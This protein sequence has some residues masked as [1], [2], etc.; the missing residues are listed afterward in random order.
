MGP[1]SGR[2]QGLWLWSLCFLPVSWALTIL[3]EVHVDG[4]LGGSIIIKCPIPKM[5]VRMYLCR[6]TSRP[7]ICATVV[8]SNNFIKKEYMGR[9]TLLQ[10]P[11]KNLFLVKMT[12]LT[13]NDSGD[14]A[15][16]VGTHTDRGK[17]QKVTLNIHSEYEPLWEEDPMPEPPKWFH[18]FLHQQ[19]PY[20]FQMPT[21]ASSSKFT[22]KVIT[23]AQRTE[24]PPVYQPSTTTLTIHHPRVSRASSVAAA[25]SPTLLPSTTV[26]KTSAQEGLL[27]P[28]TASYN[29]HS[30]LHRQRAFNHG[31]HS[32]REG[33]GFHILIPTILGL[34]LI[35]L[36][37]LL[38]K[39]AI[40][41]RKALSRRVRRLAV[42]MRALEAS[43]RP[44]ASRRLRSQNNVYSA[45]PRRARP[46]DAAGEGEAPVPG[47][48]MS[49]PPAPPQE[50]EAPWL[51][52]S[53]LKT[54]S[55]YIP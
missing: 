33:Q 52:A 6:E 40:Q 2:S 24:T 41:R 50:Y 7:G 49:A 14:Y 15:C 55:E 43:Q 21:H 10:S 25:K 1:C 44:L 26:S 20:W 51:H 30:R 11:D 31:L 47:P 18:Q 16:G 36:V 17:T 42:R 38:V 54:G 23:R 8:S 29:H 5:Q 4:E 39:R 35:A 9:V 37:G 32:G 53:S 28:Q 12:E 27:R 45:C 19:V 34:F 46:A 48:G 22:S 13:E 3:P